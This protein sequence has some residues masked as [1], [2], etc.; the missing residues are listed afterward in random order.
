KQPLH[1]V[2]LAYPEGIPLNITQALL[3]VKS[4]FSIHT[5]LHVHLHAKMTKK[6]SN[7]PSGKV[8]FRKNK[9]LQ[10]LTSLEVL[11]QKLKP[12]YGISTWYDY[13][14]EASQRENYLAAKKEIIDTWVDYHKEGLHLAVDIG[15][16][17]GDFS[18]ML[19]E[20][21]INTIAADF[22]AACIDL[23]YKEIKKTKQKNINP[24]VLD[25]ANP[26][27]ASGVNYEER[28]S[29]SQRA[30]ADIALALA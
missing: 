25:A 19:S 23:L 3:P 4:K 8:I 12:P 13:Y 29:F 9:I 20:K 7:S 24:L 1:S 14:S 17:T 10:L 30:K 22:D 28:S 5:Y 15:A 26:S 21:G 18:L 27:P 2:M 11:I 16:N 6:K